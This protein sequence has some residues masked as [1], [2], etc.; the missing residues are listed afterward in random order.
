MPFSDEALEAL[1]YD[2][3]R[4]LQ[5]RVR[6]LMTQHRLRRKLVANRRSLVAR[7]IVAANRLHEAGEAKVEVPVLLNGELAPAVARAAYADILGILERALKVKIEV[8]NHVQVVNSGTQP[9]LRI[10]ANLAIMP[11]LAAQ[12]PVLASD[13]GQDDAQALH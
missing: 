10:S 1:N 2:E 11:E 3:L 4:L 9:G 8:V 7:V 6:T 13:Q 12:P 5:T